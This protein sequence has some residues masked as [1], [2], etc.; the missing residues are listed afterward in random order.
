[1]PYSLSDLMQLVVA[2]RGEA[3]HL[4]QNE[5]PV[6]EIKQILHRIEG[7]PVAPGE[8]EDVLRAIAPRENLRELRRFK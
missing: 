6:L 2:E 3:V 1:M 4:H 5:A 8:T 7:P